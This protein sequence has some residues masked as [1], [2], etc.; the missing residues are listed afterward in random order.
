MTTKIGSGGIESRPSTGGTDRAIKRTANTETNAPQT[1]DAGKSGG[2]GVHITDSAR[3]LAAL[4]QA[5]RGMPEVNDVKVAEI[6]TAIAN[7]TYEV[8]PDRIADKL[9]RLEQEF[10]ASNG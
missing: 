4:E 1:A 7:G 9:L 6:R 10:L 5:I 3:Q 8:A 2:Q